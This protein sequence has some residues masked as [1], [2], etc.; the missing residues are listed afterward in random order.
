MTASTAQ[1]RRLRRFA[2]RALGAL[3]ALTL[4]AG[5]AQ[6]VQAGER[7]DQRAAATS[8]Q[9]LHRADHRASSVIRVDHRRHDRYRHDRYRYDRRK[10]SRRDVIHSLRARGFHRI[11]NVRRVGP[12]YRARAVGRRGHVVRVVLN[13]RSGRILDVL[14]IRHRPSRHH[15]RW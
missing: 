9:H 15:S 14:R 2:A 5:M 3:T 4:V 7:T 12:V 1:P 8:S 13:A 10:M 6:G 11:H